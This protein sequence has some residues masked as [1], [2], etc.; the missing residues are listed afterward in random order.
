MFLSEVLINSRNAMGRQDLASP[1][2]LHRTLSSGFPDGGRPRILFRQ[3]TNG[4]RVM[5]L[6]VEEPSFEKALACGRML[7][8]RSKV[9]E[10]KLAAGQQLRFRLLANPTK[11]TREGGRGALTV[12]GEQM[13]WLAKKGEQHGYRLLSAH[14]VREEVWKTARPE[15]RAMTHLA[16]DFHGLL[17]V[18]DG[19]ALGEA[20][21]SGIGS[22]KAFGFGMLCVAR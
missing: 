19:D 7:F 5:M 20:L 17:D 12:P 22:A 18:T 8:V 3:E 14:I 11:K 10:P 2:E 21:R 1:Y 9:F 6:S 15:G 16:V 13:A 4:P